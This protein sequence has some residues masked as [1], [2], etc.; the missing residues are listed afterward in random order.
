MVCGGGVVGVQVVGEGMLCNWQAMG[1][2]CCYAVGDEEGKMNRRFK[3]GITGEVI[4]V[5]L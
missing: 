1:R 2:L 5:F 4:R 3:G